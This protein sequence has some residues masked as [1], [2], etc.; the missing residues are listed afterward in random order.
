[1]K[2]K[3]NQTGY[4]KYKDVLCKHIYQKIK[5]KILNLMKFGKIK[6]ILLKI[7]TMRLD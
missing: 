1:M 3:T 5:Y 7:K 6:L 2:I 4:Q